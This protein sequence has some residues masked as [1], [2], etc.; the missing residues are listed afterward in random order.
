MAIPVLGLRARDPFDT[1]VPAGVAVAGEAFLTGAA[2]VGTAGDTDT[3]DRWE[4]RAREILAVHGEVAGARP[5][6]AGG[7]LCL[8]EI[9][10]SGP[11]RAVV[12]RPTPEA[13]RRLRAQLDSAALVLGAGTADI[14]PDGPETAVSPAVQICRDGVC[15]RVV[16]L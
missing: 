11:T 3:A 14:H 16:P 15:G 2:V 12:I 4:N 1:A 8:G 5:L 10:V 13:L 9:A 7:W 6:Q